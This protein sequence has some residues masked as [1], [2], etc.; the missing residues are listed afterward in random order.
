MKKRRTR[1]RLAQTLNSPLLLSAL[2][3]NWVLLLLGAFILIGM[4]VGALVSAR[5]ASSAQENLSFMLG[6]YTAKRAGQSFWVT[7]ASSLEAVFLYFIVLFI[8]GVS[9]FGVF[10]IP[11]ALFFRGLGLGMVMGYLYA[12]FGWNG[13]FYSLALI[14]PHA[15]LSSVVLVVMARESIRVSLRLSRVLLP[16]AKPAALWPSFKLYCIRGGVI[17][18]LLCACALLDSTLTVLFGGLFAF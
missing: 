14:L 16:N 17:V 15:F 3:N 1:G 4:C 10:F 2:K 11:F 9:V 12:S 18:I 7:F 8:C 5:M 13:F 6:E